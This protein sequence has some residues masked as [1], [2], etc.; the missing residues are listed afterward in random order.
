MLDQIAAQVPTFFTRFTLEFLLEAMGRTLAMTALGCG[1][2]IVLGTLIAVIRYTKTRL[3]A[4]VRIV[5]TMLVEVFR[6][7]P[8]LVNLF[9]VMFALQG[10]GSEVSLFTIATVS[11][12]IVA[13]AFLSEVIRAGLES[14]PRQQIE[15]AEVMNL[16]FTRTLFLVLLPQSWKVILP[17]AFAFMV[18]FIKD[19][20]LASQMGVV[21]L[22]FT[23]KVLM[24]RGFSPFLVYGAVLAAYFILSYPLSR[25]GAYLENRLASPRSRKALKR[26]RSATGSPRH[27]TLG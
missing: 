25:L 5:L 10:F 24:N 16:G 27:H 9:I 22:T 18:M 7:I 17:P 19:T 26:I 4:P 11:I 14:V 15:A 8:F 1:V 23:G 3:L 20:S 13:T 2:G 6:R 12:C 21:E